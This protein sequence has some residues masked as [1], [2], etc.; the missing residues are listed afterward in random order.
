M[1]TL[2]REALREFEVA[3]LNHRPENLTNA[4]P[5][6]SDGALAE[7]IERL[8]P[9]R[10]PDSIIEIAR[11][12]DGGFT[13]DTPAAKW[14]SLTESFAHRDAIRNFYR[15]EVDTWPVPMMPF[16]DQWFPIVD[17]GGLTRIVELANEP[18]P[19][20]PVWWYDHGGGPSLLP[21]HSSVEKLLRVSSAHCR[22]EGDPQS[23]ALSM[24][25]DPGYGRHEYV[26]HYPEN[27]PDRW[28]TTI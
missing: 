18:R 14:L 21:N 25:L 5:P 8:A 4:A 19:D 22:G 7:V 3:S 2:V 17:S 12:H 9:L 26:E 1:E 27:W 15:R 11:W 28:D 10:L 16:P 23:T 24:K 6:I 13:L 20:S